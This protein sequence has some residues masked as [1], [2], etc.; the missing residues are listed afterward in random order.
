MA[1][2]RRSVRLALLL[3]VA[4]LGTTVLLGL[5][6]RAV[7]ASGIVIE[8]TDPRAVIQT[9]GSRIVQADSL[10][11]NFNVVAGRQL[12]YPDGEVRM[13]GGVEVEVGARD[14]REGFVLHGAEAAIDGDR[15]AVLL[16][17]DVRFTAGSGLEARSEQASYTRADGLVRMPAAAS[18]VR[19]GLRASGRQAVY[20]RAGDV[21]RLRGDAVV[22]LAA[23]ED[24]MRIA[25]ATALIA[26][27]DGYM[28]FGGGVAVNA[29]G[30][31]MAASRARADFTGEM[32]SLESLRL[33]DGAR[34]LGGD[35]DPGRLRAMTAA[36]IRLRYAAADRGLEQAALTGDARLALFGTGDRGTT[37]AAPSMD[38]GF[39]PDGGGVSSLAARGG[40]VLD[41]GGGGSGPP[42]RISAD[43]LRGTSGA[44]FR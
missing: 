16:S 18:F 8:R 22:A 39:A 5:R 17:G 3:F 12:T 7:P 31:Q 42:Q 36:D 41:V 1:S 38:V 43:A 33:R 30:L 44:G 37:I 11:D 35:R 32:A 9:R 26:Q 27:T 14:D 6:E 10:G 19:D 25:A 2:W 34:I 4:G 29:D 13:L 28:T 40:V 24:P 20:E 21:L 23:S 15:A